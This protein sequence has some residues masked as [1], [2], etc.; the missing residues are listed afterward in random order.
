MRDLADKQ[1]Q[2]GMTGE[3]HGEEEQCQ[4]LDHRDATLVRQ[5]ERQRLDL[6]CFFGAGGLGVHGGTWPFGRSPQTDKVFDVL[7]GGAPR[8]NRVIQPSCDC[9][10]KKQEASFRLWC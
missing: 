6:W 9:D 3:V 7:Q 1:Q 8:G 4:L 5:C 2:V 10:A